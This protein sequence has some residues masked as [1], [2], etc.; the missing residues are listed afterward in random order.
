M[1]KTLEEFMESEGWIKW[2]TINHGKMY[3]MWRKHGFEIDEEDINDLWGDKR[4][5]S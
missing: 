3:Y 4:N 1:D 2:E 5:T